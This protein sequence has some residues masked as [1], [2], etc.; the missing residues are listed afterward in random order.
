MR[1]K[2]MPGRSEIHGNNDIESGKRAA[3]K[4]ELQPFNGHSLKLNVSLAVKNARYARNTTAYIPADIMSVVHKAYFK[5]ACIFLIFPAPC[6][7][8]IRGWIPC[9]IPV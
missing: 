7:L 5:T 6:P 2:N 1:R 4:I 9:A 8:L 3:C